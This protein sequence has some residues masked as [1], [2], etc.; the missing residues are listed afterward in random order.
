[1]ATTTKLAQPSP[2]A[3][4]LLAPPT[5]RRPAESWALARLSAI[6]AHS[7]SRSLAIVAG[8]IAAVGCLDYLVGVRISLVLFYLFP[9]V[10]SVAWFGWRAG[11][12]TAGTCTAVRVIGDLANGGYRYPAIAS[13]N[14][15]I[16]L[17]MYFMVVWILSALISLLR[18][19]DERVRQRTAALQNVIAERTRLQTELF[20][21]S[22]RE[23]S[24]IGHD[25]H[26]G[27]G[28]HLTATSIAANLLAN[29]LATGSHA[30]AND[31]RTVVHMLHAAI[32]TTRTIARGLLLS[33]VGPD[34]LLPE[35]EELAA[36]L[37][38]EYPIAFRF[39]HRDVDPERLSVAAASHLF[40]IAQEAARNA[41]RHAHA[42]AVEIS[43]LAD[44]HILELTVVDNGRGLVHADGRSEGMGLRIMD[45][46]TELIGGEFTIGPGTDGGTTV[47][48]LVPLGASPTSP[49]AL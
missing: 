41:A 7:R 4:T 22:R 5:R 35:L 14:R 18:E 39:V 11:C 15:L 28:Q 10:L 45:H 25:L 33:T 31:A 13:W 37:S 38:H 23:R 12:V 47:R 24:T 8:L 42:T 26:D 21:I 27:L 16:D 43:M 34:E 1:M 17:F 20:E 44:E 29:S 49:V 32:G 36:A 30:N 19:V 46:R 9:I 2:D 6:P 3:N 40:Y 48:C